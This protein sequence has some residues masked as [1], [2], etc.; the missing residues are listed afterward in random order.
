VVAHAVVCEP[1]ST[2]QIRQNWEKYWEKRAN[3]R[4]RMRE[5][6]KTPAAQAFLTILRSKNN[7]ENNSRKWETRQ[8]KWETSQYF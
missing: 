4:G 8:R 1:V 3:C 2:F 6:Q 5:M 7:W